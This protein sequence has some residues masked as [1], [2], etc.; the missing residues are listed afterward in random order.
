MQRELY[1]MAILITVSLPK[2]INEKLG[3][4]QDISINAKSFDYLI[5]DLLTQYPNLKNF[6]LNDKSNALNEG[7]AVFINKKL[8][9]HNSLKDF[10]FSN[11]DHVSFVVAYSGG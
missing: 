9:Q 2:I 5:K 8:V 11:N 10:S 3:L 7:F 1:I 4:T 6:I